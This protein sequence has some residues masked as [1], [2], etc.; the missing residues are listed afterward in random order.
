[1]EIKLTSSAFAPG[2]V[3]PRRFTCDGPDLS[4][5]LEW[6][7]EGEAILTFAL[8]C[9]DPDPP[10]GN[11]VHWVI[12]NIAGNVRELAEG[13]PTQNVLANGTRQGTN[14]F[15][16]IGYGGPC[17]PGGI[18]RYFF[19]M[20]ALDAALELEAGA[21]RN[22]LLAAIKGHILAEGEL[23]GKYLR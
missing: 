18:H 23:M 16:K 5:P 4:P 19:R 13:I 7:V 9:D 12:Y 2:G 22:Q 1:M 17:P 6:K 14:D 15:R 11:W 8:V 3:I 20:Y 21:N 10:S